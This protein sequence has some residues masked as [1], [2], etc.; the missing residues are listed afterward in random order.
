MGSDVSAA[1]PAGP[2]TERKMSVSVC[3]FVDLETHGEAEH[4]FTCLLRTRSAGKRSFVTI[5]SYKRAVCPGQRSV[6]VLGYYHDGVEFIQPYTGE[7]HVN[8]TDCDI[9][10][11]GGEY[12]HLLPTMESDLVRATLENRRRHGA[13]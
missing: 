12:Y 1:R 9:P 11:V 2:G 5:P 10:G 6:G 13:D 8:L 7:R 3:R 4:L